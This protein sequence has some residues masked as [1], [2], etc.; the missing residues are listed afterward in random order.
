MRLGNVWIDDISNII[1]V[2]ANS[3]NTNDYYMVIY[4]MTENGII[5]NL[6]V[7]Y[8]QLTFF[9]RDYNMICEALEKKTEL[10]VRNKP[11]PKPKTKEI[12]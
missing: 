5:P 8:S 1:A 11:G 10:P 6:T 2:T 12:E 9:E 7:S 3:K 4:Y